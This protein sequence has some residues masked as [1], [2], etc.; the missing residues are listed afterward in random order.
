MRLYK[1]CQ[2]PHI[3]QISYEIEVPA[4]RPYFWLV[5]IGSGKGLVPSGNKP[6]PDPMS[7]KS[8]DAIR[9]C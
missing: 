1:L 3:L 2:E 4:T 8:Y 7:T 9:H 5:N 6:L